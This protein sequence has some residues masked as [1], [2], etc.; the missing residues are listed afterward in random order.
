MRGF[1]VKKNTYYEKCFL[2]ISLYLKKHKSSGKE[3]SSHIL[4]T[5]VD[6]PHVVDEYM[7]QVKFIRDVLRGEC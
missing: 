2:I 7:A 4:D 5:I 1:L 3:K 6:H